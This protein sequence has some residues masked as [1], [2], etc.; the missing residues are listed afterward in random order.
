[1]SIQLHKCQSKERDIYFK[2]SSKL[3]AFG[4]TRL[5]LPSPLGI[6]M[7]RW[8][9]ID[10]VGGRQ[11]RGGR[12]EGEEQSEVAPP[13][14]EGVDDVADEA[15]VDAAPAVASVETVHA[16]TVVAKSSQ[17]LGVIVA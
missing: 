10:L 4:S 12:E 14:G 13:V 17:R 16:F 1:M 9:R 5:Y 6:T 2:D 3:V 11:R 8:S 7:G 15:E